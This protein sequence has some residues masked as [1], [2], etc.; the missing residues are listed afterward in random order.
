MDAC[1]AASALEI[2]LGL[3]DVLL[4]AI[5]NS[6]AVLQSE[7]LLRWVI[8][9]FP[10]DGSHAV[11]CD[12]SRSLQAE[13]LFLWRQ[14]AL[15]IERGVNPRRMVGA[16]TRISLAWL[17]RW[18][19]WRESRLVVR[20]ETLIRWHRAGWKLFWRLKPLPGRLPIPLETRELIRRM[21][22]EN[23][24][25]GQERIADELWVKSGIQVS[26]RTVKSI[27][28][29]VRR[30]DREGTCAGRRSCACMPRGSLPAISWS[31]SPPRFGYC[32]W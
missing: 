10:L 29:G 19:D 15:Y 17:S 23:P 31:P 8:N 2:D 9:P 22:N 20:P 12:T 26:P 21:A 14:L 11:H 27:C 16:A 25:W 7:P 4:D 6:L 5:Q 13:N 3:N 1:A 28:R 18:F 30:V 24:S 32:S